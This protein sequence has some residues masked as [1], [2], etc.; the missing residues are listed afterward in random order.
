MQKGGLTIFILLCAARAGFAAAVPTVQTSFS[1]YGLEFELGTMGKMALSHPWLKIGDEEKVKPTQVVIDGRVAELT[2]KNGGRLK[3]EFG[4]EKVV[5][6]FLDVPGGYAFPFCEMYVPFVL[7][8]G[9]KW[10]VDATEGVFPLNFGGAK[11]YQKPGET[12][13]IADANGAELSLRFAPAATWI[14]VQDN[15]EWNWNIFFTGMNLPWGLHTWEVFYKFDVSK[16]ACKTLV[17]KFG[18][19][20]RDY[21]GKIAEASELTADAATEATYYA[22]LDYVGKMAKKGTRFDRFGGVEGTGKALKLKATG[23][24][25]V[26]KKRVKGRERWFLVDPE[27]NAFFHLGVC[28]F[29]PS[30]D[31]TDVTGREQA[32]AWLPP[33][34]GAMGA[35]WKDTTGD[36]WNSRAVSFYKANVIRKYG[37]FDDAGMCARYVDRVK[38]LG[39]NSVGAFTTI[40]PTLRGKDF[41]YVEVISFGAPKWIETIRGVFDPFDEKSIA[42][43]KTTMARFRETAADPLLIGR[44][45]ANEQ[46]MEDLPRELPRLDASWAAKREFVKVLKD[47]YRTIAAFNKAWGLSLADFKSVA[48]TP[49]AVETKAARADAQAFTGVFLE[50]YYSLVCREY[51]AVDS[52][53]MLLGNRWQTGTANDETLCRVAGKY[54]DVISVNYYT[55]KVDP[56]FL[57]RLQARTGDR[58]LMCSEFYYTASKESNSGPF[59]QDL[60]TQRERGLA[61]RRYAEAV[62]ASGCVVGL[63]WFTLIDQAPTGRY[64][65][66]VNGERANSGLFSV[67]DRPYKDMFEG[68]L[69]AHL[70]IYRIWFGLLN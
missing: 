40:T 68:M 57:C 28:C 31:Y 20:E 63:E 21:P 29:E 32:Y 3:A 66:G 35:A 61:Y 19:V 4:D 33:H 50:A 24:F 12:L 43:V 27:G 25:H 49:L 34:E 15:R 30:N 45:L 2:Y 64:F 56:D 58:P 13:A 8:Q 18:Q 41:P 46:A 53:H 51:R 69:A 60:A 55:A 36:Y 6:T 62:A 39:F 16:Y 38:A 48:T 17:D 5:Y 59:G 10:R 26:E 23:F 67:L 47:R 11:L 52:N 1:E 22:G 54:M 65:E 42:D 70:D 9:G 37:T 44:F 7:N 14:E